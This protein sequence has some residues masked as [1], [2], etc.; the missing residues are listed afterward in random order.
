MEFKRWMEKQDWEGKQLDKDIIKKGNKLYCPEFCFFVDNKVNS[1][2][3]DPAAARG[4]TPNGVHK[5]KN[6]NK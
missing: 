1:I 6:S 3:T 4:G 2:L 5:R